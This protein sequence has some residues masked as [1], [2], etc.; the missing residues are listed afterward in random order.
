MTM[1]FFSLV[2]S[3]IFLAIVN[4]IAFSRKGT[5]AG[6][7]TLCSIVGGVF[8]FVCTG[9][10]TLPLN[11]LAVAVTGAICWAAKTRPRWFLVSSLGATGVVYFLIT[12]TNLANQ[13]AWTQ[14]KK[15]FDGPST[16]LRQ[17]FVVPTLDTPV[18][19][20]KSAL[21]C[22]SVQLAW[23]KL[24]NDVAKGPLEVQN[25]E[26]IA[27]RL[28]AAEYSEANLE[29][30]TFYAA[31]GLVK[32]GIVE[33][34]KE[35]MKQRFPDVETPDISPGTEGAV[36]YSYLKAGVKFSLPYF[37]NDEEF[38]FTDSGGKSTSV[39]SFGIRKK[40]DYAYQQLRSQVAILYI[41]HDM[42]RKREMDEFILDPCKDSSPH[43]I[44]LARVARKATLAETLTDVDKKTKEQPSDYFPLKFGVR[45]TLLI[46]CMHW[47]VKHHFK[48]LEGKDKRLLNPSLR[49][50]YMDTN[51]QTLD[52]RID[53]GGAELSSEGKFVVLPDLSY[54]E[55]NRPYLIYMKKRGDNQ[56]FFVM[57]VENAEIMQGW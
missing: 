18:P 28:N 16:S 54:F 5:G 30:N 17:T 38:T 31:A 9:T 23:D 50:L 48:E 24:K 12:L 13:R 21:W 3:T 19:E 7:A 51:L 47:R 45:D 22:A 44:V 2:V 33:R 8:V 20:G 29:Q 56:P 27:S 6:R 32:D 35:E 11:A 39:K 4:A 1:L 53:R 49:G 37:E 42:A 41:H 57:W 52:F 14:L 36:A 43:Q 34:I 10:L 15:S 26:I 46:P 25:A 55:F 40:D